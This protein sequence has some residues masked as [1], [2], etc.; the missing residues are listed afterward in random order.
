MNGVDLSGMLAYAGLFCLTRAEGKVN[1]LTLF[2]LSPRMLKIIGIAQGIDGGSP[3]IRSTAW[4]L[5]LPRLRLGLNKSALR[6]S[7]PNS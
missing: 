7:W 3:A 6:H 4:A 2:A 5:R 1:P